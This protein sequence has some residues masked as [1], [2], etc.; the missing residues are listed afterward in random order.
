VEN[1]EK[2]VNK[3]KMG[4]VNGLHWVKRQVKGNAPANDI[5]RKVSKC[6]S[7]EAMREQLN[8]GFGYVG[9]LIGDFRKKIYNIFNSNVQP[10]PTFPTENIPGFLKENKI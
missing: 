8:R 5:W 3:N 9:K 4:L 10:L 2:Y 1:S 6:K 7:P